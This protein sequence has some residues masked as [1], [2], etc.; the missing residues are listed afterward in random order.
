MIFVLNKL[1]KTYWIIRTRWL[2]PKENFSSNSVFGTFQENLT[3]LSFARKQLDPS[4]LS[5]E[6]IGHAKDLQ[7]S[8]LGPYKVH[9]IKQP[10]D[11]HMNTEVYGLI[12]VE[13]M[14][15]LD[16][17]QCYIQ[18]DCVFLWFS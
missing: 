3:L 8:N 13:F 10:E 12:F 1:L 16:D 2:L 7:E 18:N 6:N 9:A 17:T 5:E 11:R 14:E 15:Q 4:R